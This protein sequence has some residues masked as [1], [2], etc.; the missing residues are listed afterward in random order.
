M[1]EVTEHLDYKSYLELIDLIYAK[2]YQQNT[3]KRYDTRFTI[4]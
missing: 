3:G 1:I 2:A 4:T